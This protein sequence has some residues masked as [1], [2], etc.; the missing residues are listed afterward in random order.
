MEVAENMNL[1]KQYLSFYSSFEGRLNRKNFFLCFIELF[2]FFSLFSCPFFIIELLTNNTNSILSQ[3]AFFILTLLYCIGMTSVSVKRLHDLNLSGYWVILPLFFFVVFW[4][5]RLLLGEEIGAQLVPFPLMMVL[6]LY[7][8]SGVILF[9]LTGI[10]LF[11]IKGTKGDNKYGLDLLQTENLNIPR[12][13]KSM[14][15]FLVLFT[16][17]YT[18]I[19]IFFES[20]KQEVKKANEE[21]KKLMK[22]DIK[23]LKE[24]KD[25]RDA[26]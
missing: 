21:M 13:P 7:I 24:K 3:G 11:F 16:C 1:L 23:K 15:F 19:S 14:V 5:I 22:Q 2:A 26:K 20:Q 6:F 8:C 18:P 9:I 17:V 12:L 25:I 10:I 4:I